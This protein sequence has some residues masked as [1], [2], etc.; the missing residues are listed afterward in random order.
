MQWREL[1]EGWDTLIPTFPPDAKGAAS[2][3]TS[4]QV[5]N[6]VAQRVPWL[7][8][9]AADLSPSTKTH[10]TFQGAGDFE[11]GQWAGRNFHFGIREHAMGAIVNGLSL[12]KLRPFGASFFIFSEYMKQ[13]IR[14][15]ALMEIPTI[16]VFTHDSVGVGED[17]PT[18]QPVEQLAALRAMPGLLEF[19]PGDA[20]EVAEVWRVVMQLH[21]DPAVL[22]LSRQA[23]P[24]LDR[25]K[26]A[27]ASGVARGAY[28][29]SDPAQGEPEVILMATGTEVGLI[30]QAGDVLTQQGVRVRLVSMP[31]WNLFE[32]QPREYRESVLPPHLT[33]RVAV[34]LATAFGWD[35][36]TGFQGEIIAMHTFGTSA[37]L[38]D[39]SKHFGFTPQRVVEAALAQI[40]RA[41]TA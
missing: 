20:N 28:I 14:L 17:G 25:T 7:R 21:H 2:R 38:K 15:S 5:L 13:P 24:T 23:M 3:E 19:R 32:R 8:G 4:G 6:A 11:A 41:P 31:S 35:R 33:A 34:E 36:Y 29:L 18:H 30:A 16:F 40:G 12:S 9:G 1:P 37:P 10:M 26:Y 22:V 27:P 39:V